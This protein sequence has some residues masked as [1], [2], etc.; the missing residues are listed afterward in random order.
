TLLVFQNYQVDAA[1]GYLGQSA[2]LIPVQAPEAT[3]YALTIAVKPGEE[4]NLRLIYDLSRI[5]PDT[6]EAIAAD[7]PVI[8]ATL[9]ASQPT[10]TVADILACLPAERRGKAAAAPH[11]ANT[12]RLKPATAS[13]TPKG[14]TECRLVEI[15]SELLGRSEFGV[16]D[17]F[18]DAGGQSLLLLRMHRLIESAF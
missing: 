5:D 18:F 7:L 13:A 15:W 14:E 10:A 1:I 2:R 4:L 11:A 9:V 12:L 8:V 6:V 16:D 17:N 3:N